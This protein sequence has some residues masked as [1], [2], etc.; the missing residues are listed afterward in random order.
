[1]PSFPA[2]AAPAAGSH[3]HLPRGAGRAVAAT[4][5]VG[6]SSALL[7][8]DTAELYCGSCS[9]S[10]RTFTPTAEQRSRVE[11]M[12]GYGL[13]EAEICRLIKNPETS[14]PIDL[15]ALRKHF[16]REIATGATKMNTRVGE[17]IFAFILREEGGI[18]DEQARVRLAI[19]Y[20]KT[21]M[22]WSQTAADRRER[23]GGPI[24]AKE[25]RQRVADK[26]ARLARRLKAGETGESSE[27]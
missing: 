27:D 4:P 19:F 21:R 2:A 23:V 9:M 22:G 15:T 26:I 20:A 24:N 11:A 7:V 14:K 3:R 12:I 5:V 6:W 16:A 25:Q 1:M 10:R 17:R 18:A 8:G 13:P